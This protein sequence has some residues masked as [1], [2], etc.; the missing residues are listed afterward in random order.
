MTDTEKLTAACD[1]IA[2]HILKRTWEEA[3]AYNVVTWLDFGLTEAAYEAA[4]RRVEQLVEAMQHPDEV[5]DAACVLLSCA[6]LSEHMETD[7]G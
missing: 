5:Y 1:T 3:V 2:R 6:L 4:C 7:H